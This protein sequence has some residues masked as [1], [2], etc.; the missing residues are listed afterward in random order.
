MLFAEI[1]LYIG[2]GLTTFPIADGL[3][4]FASI[5]IV[6]YLTRD[7]LLRLVKRFNVAYVVLALG[8]LIIIVGLSGIG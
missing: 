8:I 1:L 5:F 3:I 7:Y 6:G 4:L 2:G